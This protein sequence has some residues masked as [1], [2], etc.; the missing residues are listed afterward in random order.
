MCFINT[1]SRLHFQGDYI[2]K[3]NGGFGG[4]GGGNSCTPKFIFQFSR[5]NIKGK[6]NDMTF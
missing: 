3:A 2:V 1:V 5:Q 6:K 4:G